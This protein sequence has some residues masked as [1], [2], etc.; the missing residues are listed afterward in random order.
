V[1]ERRRYEACVAQEAAI[2]G[3]YSP[4]LKSVRKRVKS[5]TVSGS[6]TS[7]ARKG[8]PPRE[9]GTEGL[10]AIRRE[11]VR[12]PGKKDGHARKT[13]PRRSLGVKTYATLRDTAKKSGVPESSKVDGET[14]EHGSEPG[15]GKGCDSHLRILC[16]PRPETCN[17]EQPRT[18][19][20]AMAGKALGTDR[21]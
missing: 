16:S 20:L 5:G 10:R 11:P 15:T 17:H 19:P 18:V 8:A 6:Q 21:V 9:K 2:R 12:W 3:E 7:R 14:M 4:R 1:E 13:P